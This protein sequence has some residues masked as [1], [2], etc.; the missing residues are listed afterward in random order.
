MID[1]TIARMT[2]SAG[3]LGAK[4]DTSADIAF[5]AAALIKILPAIELPHWLWI[6]GAAIAIIK[7]ANI[8]RGYDTKKQFIALHTVMNKIAGLLLFLL[9][10]TLPFVDVN[11]S[12]IVVCA[13]ATFAAI[14]EGVYLATDRNDSN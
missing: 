4:I 5:A 2:K 8:I 10:F 12:F 14:Q 6:W 3:Q 9:P 11:Y 13:A 1:G 7:I